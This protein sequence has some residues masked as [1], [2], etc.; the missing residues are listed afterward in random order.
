MFCGIEACLQ[1]LAIYYSLGTNPLPKEIRNT[2]FTRPLN[3]RALS[4]R[5][6][7]VFQDPAQSRKTGHTLQLADTLCTGVVKETYDEVVD[8]LLHDRDSLSDVSKRTG[9][10]AKLPSKRGGME[11]C[12]P[13]KPELC[14]V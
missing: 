1:R 7:T 11:K 9:P 5:N 6:S 3:L 13:R 8:S 14:T 4:S 12:S 2:S 10:T